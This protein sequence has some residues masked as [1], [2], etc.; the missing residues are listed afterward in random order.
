MALSR[1]VVRT[2]AFNRR[3]PGPTL[4]RANGIIWN[5]TTSDLFVTAFYANWEPYRERLTYANAGHNPPLLLRHTGRT[6]QLRGD[7]IAMGVLEHVEI[8]QHEVQL[9]P[10][11][12]VI[13]YTDGVT[14]AVNEDYDEFGLERLRL[15]A[16]TAQDRDAA[17]IMAAITS[18]IRDFAGDTPQSDDVTLI[19]MKRHA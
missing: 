1:T 6:Q 17:G 14:E 5:D 10:G 15:A 9:R 2:I 19:V 4:E 13:Y 3:D 11:D 7:G 12:T 16:L 18:A 8:A